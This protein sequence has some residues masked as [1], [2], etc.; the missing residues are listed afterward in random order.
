MGRHPACIVLGTT[1]WEAHRTPLGTPR[2]RAV[3]E[4]LTWRG[5]CMGDIVSFN[6]LDRELLLDPFRACAGMI[7]GRECTVRRAVDERA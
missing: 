3:E 2:A 7:S 4:E 1:T 5:P 6:C